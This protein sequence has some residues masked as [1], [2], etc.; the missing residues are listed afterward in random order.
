VPPAL[1][2]IVAQ[3]MAKQPADRYQTA[4]ELAEAL[5]S[6]TTEAVAAK[7]SRAVRVFGDVASWI[8]IALMAL[9][10]IAAVK[11]ALPALREVPIVVTISVLLAALGCLL[12]FFDAWTRGQA[13]LSKLA[14]AFAGTTLLLGLGATS[15]GLTHTFDAGAKL[16]LSDVDRQQIVLNGASEALVGTIL[17]STLTALQ[18]VMWAMARRRV[19]LARRA[20]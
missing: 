2:K 11:M 12:S 7:G 10:T 6:F 15:L 19:E 13:A 14:L 1:A 20:A 3:A 17:A 16:D 8:G 9:L 4:T 5:E 18:L